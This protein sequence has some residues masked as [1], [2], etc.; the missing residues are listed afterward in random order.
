MIFEVQ[1]YRLIFADAVHSMGVGFLVGAVYQLLSAFMYKNKTAVFV[2]DVLICV[3]FTTVLFSYCVSFT[4]YRQLRWYNVAFA[5]AG[6]LLFT[7]AFSHSLHCIL[8]CRCNTLKNN[9]KAICLAF[10]GKLSVI[11]EKNRDKKLKNSQKNQTE[12]LKVDETLLYN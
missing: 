1:S 6:R 9:V 8:C 4:N 10:C 11:T 2:K 5:L 12:V 7:P 3:F